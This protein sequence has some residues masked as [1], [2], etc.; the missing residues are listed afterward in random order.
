METQ[1]P[2]RAIFSNPF[3]NSDII[4]KICQ[5][6]LTLMFCQSFCPLKAFRIFSSLFMTLAHLE[7]VLPPV[8]RLTAI[9]GMSASRS[10]GSV[11]CQSH[12]R[13][14]ILPNFCA[15]KNIIKA[16]RYRSPGQTYQ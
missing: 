5:E 8:W 14:V 16:Q 7:Y 11:H 3:T 1:G 15:G 13:S 9:P 6:S 4:L 12:T 10:A 2:I